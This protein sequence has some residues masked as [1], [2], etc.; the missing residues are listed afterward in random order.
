MAGGDGATS[1]RRRRERQLRS[2]LRHERMSV[3]MAL[4]E[5]LHH[6][7]DVGSEQHVAQR[8]QK[9]ASAALGGAPTSLWSRVDAALSYTAAEVPS[10][11]Y[12]LDQ[13]SEVLLDSP[14][15]RFLAK[16]RKEE[17]EVK[18]KERVNLQYT[19]VAD[20]ARLVQERARGLLRRKRKKSGRKVPKASSRPSSTRAAR[21]S[22]SGVLLQALPFWSS[23]VDSGCAFI[24]QLEAFT[25][26]Q[27]FYVKMDLGPWDD[28]RRDVASGCC[29][30][31]TR[32]LVY[33]YTGYAWFDFGYKFRRQFPD[34]SFCV[35][36]T[37]L[38]E[39]DSVLELPEYR[40]ICLLWEMT[41][42][43]SF[44]SALWSRNG[45]MITRLS[46][47]ISTEFH[48][49]STSRLWT[50]FY[51]SRGLRQSLVRCLRH[52]QLDADSS[53]DTCTA[54]VYGGVELVYGD[55]G[56]V[57]LSLLGLC[58]CVHCRV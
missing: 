52:L 21:T 37:S 3:R 4:A 49:F 1:T 7:G 2:F 24:R 22:K 56:R 25:R 10:L 31:S 38:R 36:H 19:L 5:A 29:L 54:P 41:S 12:L 45:C 28:S 30:R 58:S 40:T 35:P 15:V 17:E 9:T 51:G 55:V 26:F 43:K 46:T 48:T 39:G 16:K 53:A 18:E 33:W 27:V 47:E 42:G 14:V 44:C 50:S 23:W 34:P 20:A 6:S 11:V 57:A 8:G 32:K 13:W